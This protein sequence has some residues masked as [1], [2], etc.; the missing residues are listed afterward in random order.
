MMGGM[1]LLPK[2]GD[3]AQDYSTEKVQ[4]LAADLDDGCFVYLSEP[5]TAPSEPPPFS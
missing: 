1:H 5:T 4:L 3:N 2:R